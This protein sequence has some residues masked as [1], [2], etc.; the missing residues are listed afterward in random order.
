[1]EPNGDP[2]SPTVLLLAIALSLLPISELRGAIPVA[3]SNGLRPLPAFLLCVAANCLAGPITFLFLE[4]LHRL[5]L[6]S[7]GYRNLF[8]TLIGRAR[9]KVASAVEKYG[10]WGLAFFVGIPLPF[11]GAYTGA[12]GA[13][14]LGMRKRKAILFICLGVLMAGVIVTVVWVLGIRVLYLFLSPPR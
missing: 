9:K 6:R 14:I 8:E 12:L 10:Y 7:P 4:T 5:F 1:L 2:M 3:I 13:W 11:T